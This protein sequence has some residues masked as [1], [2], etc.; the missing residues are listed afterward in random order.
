ML[1]R[2]GEH[3]RL[4]AAPVTA[5]LTGI[6]RSSW[7]DLRSLGSIAGNNI[8]VLIVLMMANEPPNRPSSATFYL[9][10]IGLLFLFPLSADVLRQIPAERFQLWPL[11]PFERVAVRVAALAL[12]P[13]LAIAVVFTLATRHLVVGI[14]LILL[15]VLVETFAV[16][17][18]AIRSRAPH[19]GA[20]RLIPPIPGRLGGVIQNHLRVLLG[21]L[22]VYF[23]ALLAFGGA[24]YAHFDPDAD[25]ASRWVIGLLVVLFLS[26]LAQC[27]F[28]FETSAEQMRY[29]LLPIS[30]IE[31]LFAKDLAWLAVAA[32]LVWPFRLLPCAAAA[33]AALA[34]GHDTAV[35]R[36]IAQ[37]R[38]RFAE[39][40]LA[41]T[42]FIQIVALVSGGVAVDRYGWP[43]F[44]A[45][46]AAYAGSLWWYGRLWDRS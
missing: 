13:M 23:A 44:L 46:A 26:T 34:V 3:F 24:I 18:A 45:F 15:A 41:P 7:R 40:R 6:V 39:G 5:I 35:R 21:A 32:V 22:D 28:G 25:P 10:I 38:W 42:G 9:F 30:G 14:A 16:L 36:P 33:C 12:N 1:T 11:S 4:Q 8:L 2:K 27:Q 31:V 17:T 19:L 20:F 43:L 29:R 37:R